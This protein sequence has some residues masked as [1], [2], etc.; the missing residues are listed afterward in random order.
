MKRSERQKLRTNEVAV[1]VVKARAV[2]EQRRREVTMAVVAIVVI[3]TALGGYTIWRQRAQSQAGAMLGEAMA[4]AQAQVVPLAPPT[5][6]ATPAS[7]ASATPGTPGAKPSTP[8]AT[9]TTPAAT[10]ATPATPPAPP[11]GSYP[12]ERAKLEAALPKFLAVASAYPRTTAGV[13]AKYHAAAAA[14]ALGR[15]DEALR[16]YNEVVTEDRGGVYGQMAR[17]GIGETQA[18][19]GHHD[20]A[21]AAFKELASDTASQVPLDA[22]LTQL[23]KSYALAGKTKEARETFQRV[24]S[25]FPQSPYAQTAKQEL[26]NLPS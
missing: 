2:L 10:P 8:A 4:V 25:E 15:T 12:S 3:L 17:L 23:G 9:P 16:L 14:G 24:L 7:P 5:P 20:Q 1:S 6:P 22:V 11:A 21:I 26:E 19:A 18:R 13:A